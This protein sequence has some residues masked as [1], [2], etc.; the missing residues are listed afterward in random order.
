MKNKVELRDDHIG[1]FYNH[2]SDEIINRYLKYYHNAEKQGIV[3][4]RR[5]IPSFLIEDHSINVISSPFYSEAALDYVNKPFMDEFFAKIYPVYAKKYS[6]LKECDRHTIFDMKV[7]KTIPGEGY[8]AWHIENNRMNARNRLMAFMLYL[9]DVKEGGETEFLYQKCR[10]KPTRNTLL[11][12]P[13]NYTHV[14]RGNPP[15]SHNKYILTGWIEYG[16]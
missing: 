13:A 14:H 10:F 12:W 16:L 1:I 7:Q 4:P 6:L 8:H 3:I 2:F 9:N 11:I 15:L 5:P